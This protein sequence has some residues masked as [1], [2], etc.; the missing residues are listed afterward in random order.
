[1]P[2]ERMERAARELLDEVRTLAPPDPAREEVRRRLLVDLERFLAAPSAKTH[3]GLLARMRDAV[4]AFE[5]SH[6]EITAAVSQFV[7]QFAA[8]NL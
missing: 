5:S 6:P 3:E 1:M 7:D 2:D 4:K 8:W